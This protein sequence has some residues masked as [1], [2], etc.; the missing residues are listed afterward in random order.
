MWKMFL[1]RLHM[2]LKCRDTK[3][4]PGASQCLQPPTLKGRANKINNSDNNFSN[5]NN[6]NT[7]STRK[8]NNEKRET[9]WESFFSFLFGWV[10]CHCCCNN[11]NC[12]ALCFCSFS[13]CFF[14]YCLCICCLFVV[15][16][17][18]PPFASAAATTSAAAA[19]DCFVLCGVGTFYFLKIYLPKS[20]S[21]T[22]PQTYL[23]TQQQT[24]WRTDREKERERHPHRDRHTE[25]DIHKETQRDT[26]THNK[27]ANLKCPFFASNPTFA[28]K[29]F[30]NPKNHKFLC[31]WSEI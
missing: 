20:F 11:C 28:I 9:I 16:S 25:R 29:E 2:I 7:Y 15:T 21:L 23:L 12:S 13:P 26:H 22:G 31:F 8:N 17:P 4:W 6:S 27:R 19:T 14:V 18:L 1:S 10:C 3:L 30:G 24:L 5:K